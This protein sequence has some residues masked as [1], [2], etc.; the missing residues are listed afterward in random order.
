MTK[1]LSTG[2]NIISC[3][4]QTDAYTILSQLRYIQV[5]EQEGTGITTLISQGS[6]N[7][8]SGSFSYPLVSKVDWRLL[9]DEETLS[10]FDGYWVHMNA[11]K[12]FGVIPD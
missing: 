11:L 4:G 8:F 3:A 12:S 10:P 1:S 2:W 6:Y 7:Q 9:Y 5:G